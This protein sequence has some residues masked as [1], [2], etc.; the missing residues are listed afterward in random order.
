MWG[1]ECDTGNAGS[2][3]LKESGKANKI[4]RRAKETGLSSAETCKAQRR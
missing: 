1:A 2:A 3:G 4:T